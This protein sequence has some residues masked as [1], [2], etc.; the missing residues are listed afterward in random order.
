MIRRGIAD[1]SIQEVVMK[2]AESVF[3]RFWEVGK[4][5]E[6]IKYPYNADQGCIPYT[7]GKE[8]KNTAGQVVVETTEIPDPK[9]AKK[10][11]LLVSEYEYDDR[12]NWI[13]LSSFLLNKRG[14]KRKSNLALTIKRTIQYRN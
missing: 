3:I 14:K 11:K 13:K 1:I 7:I 5:K 10:G 9:N 2:T 4:S 6:V 12:D 8:I